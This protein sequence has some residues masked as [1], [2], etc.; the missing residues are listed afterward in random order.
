MNEAEVKVKMGMDSTQLKTGLAGLPALFRES[1]HGAEQFGEHGSNSLHKLHH[2]LHGIK[3]L[4]HGLGAFAVVAAVKGLVGEMQEFAS[5]MVFG[6]EEVRQKWEQVIKA[7]DKTREAAIESGKRARELVT[8][9]LSPTDQLTV[10]RDDEK[11]AKERHDLAQAEIVEYNKYK[12]KLNSGDFTA[13]DKKAPEWITYMEGAEDRMS[14]AVIDEVEAKKK[15]GRLQKEIDEEERRQ[16]EDRIRIEKEWKSALAKSVNDQ[17]RALAPYMPSHDQ[18]LNAGYRDKRGR[19]HPSE[20]NSL[21]TEI[22]QMTSDISDRIANGS[23]AQDEDIAGDIK[24]TDDLKKQ[25]DQVL[26]NP[27]DLNRKQLEAINAM[28][29]LLG[30]TG[31]VLKPVE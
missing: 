29:T 4:L 31:I 13:A 3:I 12:A 10:A 15:I 30:T 16:L 19:F 28:V 8:G 20:G 25:L 24:Y 27:Q 5:E 23:S 7:I 9:E 2:A 11:D 14:K 1:T 17:R 6:G 21:Q 26:G 22:D 18:L